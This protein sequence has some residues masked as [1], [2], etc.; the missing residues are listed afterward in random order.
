MPF[1]TFTKGNVMTI[2]K[3]QALKAITII[4]TFIALTILSQIDREMFYIATALAHI[5]ISWGISSVLPKGI[6]RSLSFVGLLS[7]TIFLINGIN[8]LGSGILGTILECKTAIPRLYKMMAEE[9]LMIPNA[10][11]EG[12]VSEFTPHVTILGIAAILM[13]GKLFLSKAWETMVILN[14][15]REGKQT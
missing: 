2:S 4:T 5:G 6:L 12:N 13:L 8:G 10:I 3:Y 14:E 7:L 15:T 9:L 1:V 11:K